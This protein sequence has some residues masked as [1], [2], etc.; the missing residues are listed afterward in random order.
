MGVLRNRQYNITKGLS[1][2]EKELGV[3]LKINGDGDL[4]MSNLKDL[5][6]VAGAP[7]AGQALRLKLEIEQGSLPFHPNIGTTLQIGEKTKD[8]FA[9]KTSALNSILTDPRFESAR[10][11]VSVLGGTYVLD[12]FVRLRNTDLEVP[13]QLALVE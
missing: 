12:I 5:K 11:N 6:L 1:Q 9:I 2:T 8:A 4:E 3:D 10:V 13:V 7:N